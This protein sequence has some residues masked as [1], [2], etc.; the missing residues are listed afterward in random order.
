MRSPHPDRLASLICI[1]RRK[2][3]TAGDRPLSKINCTLKLSA[4]LTCTSS[5]LCPGRVPADSSADKFAIKGLS[6]NNCNASN[7][8]SRFRG[9]FVA[10][11]RRLCKYLGLSLW[12]PVTFISSSPP[13]TTLIS[14][15]PFCNFCGGI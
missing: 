10:M 7:K 3:P 11:A 6:C 13:S 14:T 1:C 12:L 4:S 15:T 9:G 5:K 8:R 2:L